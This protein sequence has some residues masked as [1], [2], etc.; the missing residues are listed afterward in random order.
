M[1][2]IITFTRQSQELNRWF[3][4]HYLRSFGAFKTELSREQVVLDD[5]HVRYADELIERAKS[6]IANLDRYQ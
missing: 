4:K 1:L 5:Y 6:L 2:P 3:H